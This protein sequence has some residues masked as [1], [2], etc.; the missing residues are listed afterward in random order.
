MYMYISIGH[1]QIQLEDVFVE[2]SSTIER[3]PHSPPP[4]CG[5][6]FIA[7]SR[8]HGKCKTCRHVSLL[9]VYN[10]VRILQ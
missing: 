1:K 10:M 4:K 3:T 9:C 5:N 6:D 2:G 8:T 7:L